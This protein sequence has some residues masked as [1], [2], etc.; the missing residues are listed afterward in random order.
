MILNIILNNAKL[1][2]LSSKKN[3]TI[4][5]LKPTVQLYFWDKLNNDLS[6]YTYILHFFNKLQE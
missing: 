4:T 6:T 5:A 2:K 3:L 1:K